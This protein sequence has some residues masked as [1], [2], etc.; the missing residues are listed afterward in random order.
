[1]GNERA[2]EIVD[3]IISTADFGQIYNNIVNNVMT[4]PNIVL[5]YPVKVKSQNIANFA[6][7]EGMW[8]QD[9][10]EE[11]ESGPIF[12]EN[13]TYKVD[14]DFFKLIHIATFEYIKSELNELKQKL[15][16][17]VHECNMNIETKMGM[18]RNFRSQFFSRLHSELSKHIEKTNRETNRN[19]YKST[20]AYILTVIDTSILNSILLEIKNLN[21][22]S[23]YAQA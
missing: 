2:K 4:E 18:V 16:Q 22:Y 14:K 13:K 10:L 8:L 5:Q 23:E 20:N 9:F 19:P 17:S 3:E 21:V 7:Y 1:M 15:D 12:I 11:D 6:Q